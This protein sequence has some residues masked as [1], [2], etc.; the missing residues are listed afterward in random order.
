MTENAVARDKGTIDFD[1]INN[2][3]IPVTRYFKHVLGDTQHLI[4]TATFKQTG[5]LR[6]STASQSWPAFT[7]SQIV[8]PLSKS[9][10][11]NA[12]VKM[13][14]A[15][16]VRVLD[17]Y[18]SGA[19]SGRVSLLSCFVVASD[20]NVTELNSGALHRYLA[21]A[22]W[23]PTALLP[24]SGV[25]WSAIDE[26]SAL[27]TLTHNGTSVSLEFRFNESGEITGIYSDGRF[28][29]FGGKYKKV[30]WQGR[31]DSYQEV[32]GMQVPQYGE[33][34]WYDNDSL[35]LVWKGNIVDAKYAFEKP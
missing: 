17:S 1:S 29:R 32:E 15:S 8:M 22:V 30:A 18:I 24:Q 35:E 19:G 3:P 16:H 26:N 9:F 13:P 27:A 10:L 11:W 28:G 2:L 6:T 34:G 21:E 33:V 12:K 20:A 23:Y 7:A 14:L 5:Q 31:F 25:Q 4:K